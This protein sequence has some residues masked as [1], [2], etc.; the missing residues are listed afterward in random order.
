MSSDFEFDKS[1]ARKSVPSPKITTPTVEVETSTADSTDTKKDAKY[2]DEEL[3]QV[4]DEIL[5][6]NEYTEDFIIRDRLKVTFRTRTAAEIQDID[7][8]LDKMGASLMSTVEGVRAF[9]NLEKSIVRYQ[10]TDL[11]AL[12][13]EDRTAFIGKL[14]GP[15]IG[16]LMMTLAKFDGKVALACKLGEENF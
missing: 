7:K 6:S 1:T 16:A 2:S 11:S 13:A 9:M 12:K 3:L 15:I 14:P 4:F 10:G 5:F 8:S